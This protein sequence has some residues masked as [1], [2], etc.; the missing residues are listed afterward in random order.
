MKNL[1]IDILIRHNAAPCAIIQ[2][3]MSD[4]RF[5]IPEALPVHLNDSFIP[6][7]AAVQKR[8]SGE[9]IMKKSFRICCALCAVLLVILACGP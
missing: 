4:S 7:Y 3:R 9:I 6:V 2:S 8:Q 1:R 5:R